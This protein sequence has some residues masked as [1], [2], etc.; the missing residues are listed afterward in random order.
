MFGF[1]HIG[2]GSRLLICLPLFRARSTFVRR[3]PEE[4]GIGHHFSAVSQLVEKSFFDKLT[5][6]GNTVSRSFS[7]EIVNLLELIIVYLV[8]DDRN[9]DDSHRNTGGNF[10]RF[11]NGDP[12][13][14]IIS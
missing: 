4:N 9:D 6:H 10:Q 5:G 8:N 2:F 1:R 13:N 12:E 7:V 14:R 3:S 11:K